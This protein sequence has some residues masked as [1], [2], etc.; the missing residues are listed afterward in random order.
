M[1]DLKGTSED[2]QEI[3]MVS[4]INDPYLLSKCS[5]FINETYFENKAYKLIYKCLNTYYRKYM[6]LPTKNELSIL[7]SEKYDDS[8]GNKDSIKNE[9]IELYNK[10]IPDDNFVYDRVTDFI[11][12]NNIEKYLN[13][14]IDAIQRSG[15]VNLDDI[16]T[17]LRDSI[18]L[19]ISKSQ[20]YNLSDISKVH[21]IREESVGSIDS[22]L[23]VKFF[24][25]AV[26]WCMQYKALPP[27]TINMIVAPPGRGKTT[28]SINQ[29][30]SCAQQGFSSLHI[31]LGDMSRYD[32]LLR[33]LSCLSGV[34]TSKLVKL[35]DE[36]LTQFIRKYNMT[37][38]LGNI[39]VLSHAAGE[40]TPSQ[41]IEEITTLQKTNKVHFHQIIIDYDENFAQETDSM[42][43]SGGNVY[44]RLALFAVL[45]KSVMFILCQPKPA[46]WN[47]EVIPL[48]A[49]AESSKKQ[50]IIDLMLTIA[51]PYKDSTVGTLNIAKNR[52]GNDSKLIRIKFCGDNARVQAI[53]EEE[54]NTLKIRGKSNDKQPKPTN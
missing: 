13:L 7:V 32:G 45:N 19:N 9:L 41:L 35:S 2:L 31:F 3:T 54:Y 38:V 42:Y 43:E 23:L 37:G 22:P 52:R 49:A 26:N 50:K 44:N 29:G 27:G 18:N 51:R 40:V 30:L 14:S 10:E 16:A 48:E 5:S 24:I 36:E 15:E 25:E 53:T 4:L 21:E 1:S 20:L 33:Y 28:V 47:N 17:G 8:Y 39:Y 46:F 12:R 11:K 34:E 6:K